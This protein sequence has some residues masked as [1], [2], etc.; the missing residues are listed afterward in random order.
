[1]QIVNTCSQCSVVGKIDGAGIYA[2]TFSNFATRVVSPISLVNK[3]FVNHPPCI[4]L[5]KCCKPAIL[6]YRFR[7]R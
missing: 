4:N 6:Y 3:D 2:F 7:A 1:M 5:L